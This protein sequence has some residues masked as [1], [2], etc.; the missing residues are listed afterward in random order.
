MDD[1][2][3]NDIPWDSVETILRIIRNLSLS[4]HIEATRLLDSVHGEGRLIQFDTIPRDIEK[5]IRFM[6]DTN[7]DI[8]RATGRLERA[9]REEVYNLSKYKGKVVPDNLDKQILEDE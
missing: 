5:N 2:C 1:C 7:Q 3:I 4:I 6:K 8:A 9:F